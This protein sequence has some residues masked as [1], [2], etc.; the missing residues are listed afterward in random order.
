MSSA[1][2]TVTRFLN[3]DDVIRACGL[4]DPVGAVSQALCLHAAG[5]TTLPEE[6][7]LPWQTSDAAAARSL[8]LPGA[9]WHDQPVIGLKIIN[10]SLANLS[11]GIPRAQGLV[12][13]FD[14]DT[15]R[16]VALMEAAFISATRTAA[17]SALTV[18][19]VGPR[20]PERIAVIGCGVLGERH[21]TLLSDDLPDT[22]FVL[23]DLDPAR[24]DE[25]AGRLRAAAIDCVTVDTA[26][27]AARAAEVVITATTTTTG[28]I[29]FDWLRPGA[30][31]AHVSLDDV[32]PDVVR[33]A[34]VLI[35]DDWPLVSSDQR[36]LLGRMYHAG[37]L[38]GAR[39]EACAPV[40]PQARR[41]DATLGDVL[42]GA[43]PGRTRTDEI[44]LSNPFGMG[45]LDVALAGAVVDVARRE[46][47]GVDLRLG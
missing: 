21:V 10:S 3:R 46:G 45:I 4:I 18:R 7:Y 32:L 33:R 11:R 1:D 37:Q 41:V 22:R 8:A 28:Y 9:L 40:A 6:A 42:T 29:P 43:H 38:T 23:H 27:E 20:R 25:L 13:L 15:A 35:V 36:R 34:D 30:L 26:E 14:R 24:R 19:T 47:L 44:V 5:R 39:G 31:I 17:Y 12:V 2:P 16:P